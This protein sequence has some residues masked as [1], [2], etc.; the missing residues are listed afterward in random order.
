MKLTIFNGSPRAKS[1]N[2]K[3]L[4]DSFISGFSAS[5]NE[6][7]EVFFLSETEKFSEYKEIFCKSDMILF[8]FPLYVDAMPGIVKL[9][10]EILENTNTENKKIGFIVHSGFP[11]SI[12]SIC[13]EKY[14]K[15][16]V[17][18]INGEYLGTVIKG[19]S[20]SLKFITEKMRNK[21]LSQFYD[22]G[23]SFG[24]NNTFDKKLAEKLAKPV[25]F[26]NFTVFILKI[27]NSIGV[28][29]INWNKILKKNKVYA[30]RFDK[31]YS[32]KN[33]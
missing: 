22:L 25:N 24:L 9:F 8:I 32:P 10:F 16:F 33:L 17:D 5:S 15:R 12:H 28:F 31:P 3:I 21:V 4:S 1:S 13:L 30:K 19:G 27:L 11:E 29:N 20:E 23:Y 6:N 2:S 14:L 26:N 18:I 7:P